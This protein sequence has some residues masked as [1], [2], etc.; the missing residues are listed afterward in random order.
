MATGQ[1]GVNGV[2]V[3]YT[4][5]RSEQELVPTRLLSTLEMTVTEVIMIP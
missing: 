3:L 5:G 4:A 1:S 2:T